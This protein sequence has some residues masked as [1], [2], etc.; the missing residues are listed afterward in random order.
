VL[1]ETKLLRALRRLRVASSHGPWVRCVR[2][3]LLQGP[4]PG[5]PTGSPPQPLWPGGAAQWGARF[6]PRGS[7]G[8][9]YLASDPI[10]AL[11]EVE[12]IF[13]GANSF[14]TSPLAIFAVQ[15]VLDRVLDLTHPEV[16]EALGTS[17]AELSG[18]WRFSEDR[19]L[20][21][22]GPLP[23]CQLLGKVAYESQRFDSIQYRSA[24]DVRNGTGW[25]VF[26]DR[27]THQGRSY[28]KVKD[29]HGV[30]RQQIP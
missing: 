12:A 27:L 21:G 26:V 15:G 5:A 29:E 2:F 28:L 4:P 20:Q 6:T 30:I 23:P 22:V 18:D 8:T 1:P 25:A 3:D 14:N 11:L 7:F 19:F 13:K 24:K 10:T 9:I 17:L 16:E